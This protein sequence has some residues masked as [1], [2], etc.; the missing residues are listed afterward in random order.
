M[1]ITAVGSDQ[2]VLKLIADLAGPNRTGPVD[3]AALWRRI[4]YYRRLGGY[5][6]F[7]PGSKYDP[8]DVDGAFAADLT[9]NVGQGLLE[10]DGD[11]VKLT[12]LGRLVSFALVL[13]AAI[14]SIHHLGKAEVEDFARRFGKKGLLST[15]C[16]YAAMLIRK[17]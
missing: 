17:R 10:I 12:A 6:D 5:Y 9:I 8:N 7:Y 14:S 1:G 3:A 4:A 11:K 2:V 16:R 13:P 15:I